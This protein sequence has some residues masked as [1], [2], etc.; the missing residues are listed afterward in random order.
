MLIVQTFFIA[1]QSPNQKLTGIQKG[2][3]AIELIVELVRVRTVILIFSLF[4]RV[5]ISNYTAF[6][7][8]RL[9]KSPL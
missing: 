2:V 3:L 4:A 5:D 8:S 6:M 9:I 7:L 1:N